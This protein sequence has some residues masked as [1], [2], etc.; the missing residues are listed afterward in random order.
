LSG[1][2]EGW[3]VSFHFAYFFEDIGRLDLTPQGLVLRHSRL[4]LGGLGGN[5]TFG[6]WLFKGE[7]AW[8]Q[9]FEFLLESGDEKSRIDVMGGVEYYGFNDTTIAVEVVNRHYFDL[10]RIVIGFPDFQ[11]QN[12]VETAIRVTRDWLH[13]RLTTTGLVALFGWRAQDGVVVRLQA[14]YTIVDA[15][16][17]TAGILIYEGGD[18]PPIDSWDPNDRV[19]LELKYSF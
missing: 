6:S 4:W 19:F 7:A 12:S 15:L 8:L 16:V 9:G 5:Y 10:D 13:A 2:F 3:D 11:R 17:A 14:D 18:L 1:V